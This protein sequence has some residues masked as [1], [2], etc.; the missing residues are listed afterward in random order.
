[1]RQASTTK[2][3]VQNTHAKIERSLWIFA[4]GLFNRALVFEKQAKCRFAQ[5]WPF[6]EFDDNMI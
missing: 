1:M 3:V 5:K 6:Q 2:R 4:G